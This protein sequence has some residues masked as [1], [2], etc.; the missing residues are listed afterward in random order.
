MHYHKAQ[1]TELMKNNDFCKSLM[2]AENTLKL[3]SNQ[4]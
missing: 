2:H 1:Q 3:R 4:V